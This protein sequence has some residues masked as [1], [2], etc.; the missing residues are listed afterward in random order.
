MLLQGSIAAGLQAGIGNVAAGSLFAMAQ[1]VA[2]GGAI[3]AVF[4]AF[5]AGVGAAAGAAAG[6]GT[7]DAGTAGAEAAA[8][9]ADAAAAS[10]DAAAA[11]A[12]AAT[13]GADAAWGGAAADAGIATGATLGAASVVRTGHNRCGKCKRRDKRYCRHQ[14]PLHHPSSRPNSGL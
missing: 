13:T 12:R 9:S 5:G 4:T 2:M 14:R 10:A 6:A 1:S 7:D 3:P 11:S 8:A